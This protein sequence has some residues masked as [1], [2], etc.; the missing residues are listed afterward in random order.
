MVIAGRI[1]AL[2]LL[3]DNMKIIEYTNRGLNVAF[4]K[5][6]TIYSDEIDEKE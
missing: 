5:L 3:D 2:T 4:D 1:P 6:L